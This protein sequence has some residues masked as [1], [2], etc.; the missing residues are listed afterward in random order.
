MTVFYNLGHSVDVPRNEQDISI[1]TDDHSS[2][3][4]RT[5]PS[6]IR[7]LVILRI[8]F[9]LLSTEQRIDAGNSPHLMVEVLFGVL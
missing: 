9:V 1:A 4:Y 8:L 7:W 2:A 6:M 5:G 3:Q